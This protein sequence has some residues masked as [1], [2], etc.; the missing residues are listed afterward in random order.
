VRTYAIA[1]YESSPGV[2]DEFELVESG[3]ED[4]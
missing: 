1:D 4:Q 2:I 3:C